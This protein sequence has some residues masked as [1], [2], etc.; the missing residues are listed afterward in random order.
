[1]VIRRS[2]REARP[3]QRLQR[4]SAAQT[5]FAQQKPLIH[6]TVRRNYIF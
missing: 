4:T 2:A 3:N 5:A 1:M 6:G